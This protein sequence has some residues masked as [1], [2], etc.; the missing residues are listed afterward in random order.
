M[1]K[2]Y[3]HRKLFPSYIILLICLISLLSLYLVQTFKTVHYGDYF[4]DKLAAAKTT[5]T[6]YNEIKHL[7]IEKDIKINPK[8]D[9]SKSGLIGEKQSPTTTDYGSI[10]AKRASI[11][12]NFAAIFVQWLK[13]DLGLKKGDTVAVT[14]T[15]SYPALDIA[16]LAAIKE[17]QL[18]PLLVFTVGAS[19]YGAN[20]PG[21]TWL[22][23]Y[24]YL[25]KQGVFNYTPVGVSIG[26]SRDY[27]YGLSKE[28]IK[29]I[30]DTINKSGY[31]FI[32]ST[33]TIDA[34]NKRMALFKQHQGKDGVKAF[35]NVGGSMAAIGLKQVGDSSVKP[36]SISIG[37]VTSL[38][39]DLIKVDDVAVR[40]LKQGIPIVNVRDIGDLVEQYQFP[41]FPQYQP[42]IGQGPIYVALEYNR[43]Y[44]LLA[45]VVNI[46]VLLLAA[47]LSRK[48]LITY[49]KS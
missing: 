14:M 24:Q 7:R 33:G 29:I 21:L 43:M 40:Y 26:G 49:K 12:P 3:W 2:M 45:L 32:D 6:A 9:P 34:I 4:Y 27:G 37:V 46:I 31:H 8:L 20:I 18:R 48:Y 39:V 10:Y 19:N 1:K 47:V 11:N 36:K 15:G 42:L 17:L 25:V 13:G 28:G 44:A 41:K 22:D 23:M 16:M 30:K 5:Y 38:P 35:I